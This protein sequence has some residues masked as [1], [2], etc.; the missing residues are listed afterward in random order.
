MLV[1]TWIEKKS[2]SVSVFSLVSLE[3]EF[4][5]SAG[6][7]VNEPPRRTLSRMLPISLPVK[8]LAQNHQQL[9]DS[10]SFVRM[11]QPVRAA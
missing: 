10:H 2:P 6:G 11:E 9:L 8:T 1:A 3:L 4:R 7:A 5:G